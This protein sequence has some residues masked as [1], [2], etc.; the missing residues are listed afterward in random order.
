MARPRR[1]LFFITS[2]GGG[3]AESHTLRVIN[4]LP[5]DRFEPLLV[6]SRRGGSYEPFLRDDVVVREASL[7]QV[8]SSAGR[9]LLG[10]PRLRAILESEQPD[11]VCSVMELP[12]VIAGT[13]VRTLRRPPPWVALV[14]S[15]PTI[16]LPQTRAGRT[17]LMPAVRYTYAKA[18][19]II[20]LS[21]GVKEDLA[22]LGPNL[23]D[24]TVV[25]HNACVDERNRMGQGS[26]ENGNVPGRTRPVVLTAGRFT[27]QKGYPHLLDAFALL[28]RS[29]DA[30]LWI[31]GQ[32][33]D[34]ASIEAKIRDLDL[35]DSVRLLG[36]QPNPQ[37][38]MRV[39]TVFALSS[40]YEGFGNVIVEALA[41]GL[42]VV[43]TDCPHGPREILE[44]ERG[45]LLVPVADPAA[46][47]ESLRRVIEDG[48]LRERLVGAGLVRAQ[49]FTGEVIAEAYADE[50]ERVIE[51]ARRR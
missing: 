7:L 36:F 27:Q 25:I 5:R 12:G 22:K 19:R 2:L 45:G 32:G 29:C 16:E 42:P 37:D 38:F 30:E 1:A 20:A 46:M 17:V 28:R 13:T 4:H 8:P 50:L 3:G 47:S 49:A 9:L 35:N 40:V 51:S 41:C 18:D 44:G 23:V 10:A 14:Q 39:S 15:P 26:G 24:R 6:V 31:L 43:A 33:P 48:P 11:V 34:R 21:H